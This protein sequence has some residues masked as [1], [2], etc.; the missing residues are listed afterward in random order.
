VRRDHVLD[1]GDE[2]AESERN[3]T[4]NERRSTRPSRRP[5]DDVRD[6][7][8]ENGGHVASGLFCAHVRQDEHGHAGK[9]SDESRA[10]KLREKDGGGVAGGPIPTKD[11]R[12]ELEREPV[13][14]SPRAVPHRMASSSSSTGPV[15]LPLAKW[16]SGIAASAA[17]STTDTYKTMRTASRKTSA[18][19]SFR[20]MNLES[21]VEVM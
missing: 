21:L 20:S 12:S 1:E 19:V 11:G 13:K 6:D 5:R 4:A 2:N 17:I 9:G 3:D 10:P 7:A 15:T 16:L 18:R 14:A 8:D